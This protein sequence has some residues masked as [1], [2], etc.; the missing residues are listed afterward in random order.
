LNEDLLEHFKSEK[1]R[2]LDDLLC[3]IGY[4]KLSTQLVIERALPRAALAS[5]GAGAQEVAA[6]GA[7]RSRRAQERERRQDRGIE[8]MLVHYARCCSPVKGDPIVGS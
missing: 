1:Y 2:D 5:A 8:D 4:G 7:H 3:A 6:V